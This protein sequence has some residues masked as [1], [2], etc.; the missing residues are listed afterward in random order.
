MIHGMVDRPLIFTMDELK[1]LPSVSRIHFVECAEAICRGSDKTVQARTGST[2]CS[3][4]TGVPLSLLL[5]EAGVQKG[6]TW[7]VAEGAEQGK[8]FKSI[9][10]EKAMDD[11]LVVYGQNGEAVRPE[12]GYPLRLLVP[13]YEGI[14]NVK[15]LRRIK[16]VDQPYM[17]M[18]NQVPQP[19]RGE[20]RAGSNSRWDRNRS[21]RVPPADKSFPAKDSTRSRPR[22]VRRRRHQAG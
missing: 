20:S 13:G 4:W 12:Q 7:I 6:A 8:H 11:V 16:V 1:R 19:A 17:S 14:N 5:K 10:I 18:M 21:S 3:E 9:P 15:W 22:V 2:S